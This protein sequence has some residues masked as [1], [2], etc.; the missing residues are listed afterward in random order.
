MEHSLDRPR[1]SGQDQRQ[2]PMAQNISGTDSPPLRIPRFF[3]VQLKVGSIIEIRNGIDPARR[4]S[5]RRGLRS[6]TRAVYKDVALVEGT[7]FFL[8]TS[9]YHTHMIT[10]ISLCANSGSTL[11]CIFSHDVFKTPTNTIDEHFDE[12]GKCF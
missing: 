4:D 12:F 3:D 10:K 9:R 7:S 2:C 6:A 8:E 1:K 11:Q 5:E